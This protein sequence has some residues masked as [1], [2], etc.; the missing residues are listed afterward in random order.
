MTIPLQMPAGFEA[1]A[2]S[3]DFTPETLPARLQAAHA[4]KAGTWGLLHVLEGEV[5]FQL[6]P[7]YSGERR[8]RA[9]ETIVIEAE[10]PHHVALSQ[11]GRIYIEF[12]RKAEDSAIS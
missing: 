11:A 3:P 4:T 6:E 8:A 12:Y 9:G 1:Y 2:R 7:P 5:L 10:V